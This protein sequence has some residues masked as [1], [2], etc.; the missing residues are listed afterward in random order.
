M[1][2]PVIAGLVSVPSGGSGSATNCALSWT[3]EDE[4]YGVPSSGRFRVNNAT[5]ADITD[6]AFSNVSANG[7]TISDTDGFLPA[8]NQ[9]YLLMTP[10]GGGQSLLLGNF[11]NGGTSPGGFA[12]G[13][14]SVIGGVSPVALSGEYF[15]TVFPVVPAPPIGD[16]LGASSITP[17]DDG[18]YTVSIG[19]MG[20][21]QDGTITT[22]S[23]V[24]V[25]IQE[26]IL[27]P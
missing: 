13:G 22:Q 10:K 21:S 24:I 7:T 16:V 9:G 6:I 5:P 25:A 15:L 14:G 23:G 4:A 26:A 18:T 2:Q 27:P 11:S 20:I 8:V 17:I 12:R 3:F 19:T 1:Q